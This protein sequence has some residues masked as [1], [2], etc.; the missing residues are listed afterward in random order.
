MNKRYIVF[1]FI[2]G[3]IALV[4]SCG[5]EGFDFKDGYQQGDETES[6]IMTDTTMGKADKS[7]YHRARIYPGLVGENVRRIQ[8]TT[9]S[10]LIDREYI[11]DFQYKVSYTPS[12]IYSTGLYAPAGENVRI[13]VPA[14]VVGL[15]AQIGVHTDNITGKDA[16]RRDAI[17]YTRKELFPGNNYV[18]NLYGGTL[19]I[20]SQKTRPTPVNLK[21]S[22]ATKA[23]DFVL[24][25]MTVSDWQ[26][27]V[28]ANDVPWMD[29]IGK[30][31]AFSVPRSLVVKLIQS[32]KMDHVDEALQL[33]DDSYEKDYY[34]W[35]GLSPT[36]VNPI[37]R[38]PSLWERG[39]MDIHPS[40]GYAHSGSP[41]I[42]QEDEYWLD[43]LTNPN[44]IKKGTSWGT[45]HEVGHNYQAGSSW[46]WS[47]LGETTNNLFIF[48]AARNRGETNRI[49]FHP[50]L[51]TSIPGALKF[52]AYNEVK[53]FKPFPTGYGLDADDPFARLTPF[54]Q[55]F[56]KVKG[57]NGESGWDFFPYIY[58]KARNENFFTS[59]DQAKKDYFFRQLCHFTGKDFHRFFFA[60]GIP[61]STAAKREMRNLYPPMANKVWDYNPLTFTGGDDVLATKYSLPRA[62]FVYTSNVSTATGESTGKIDAMQDG[63][64]DTYWHTCYSGCSVAT[65]LP[66]E[67]MIDMK[68]INAFKGFFIQNRQNNTYATKVIVRISQ[69]NKN[70]VDMGTYDLAK[71]SET[72]AQRNVM[73][74][75]TF[76]KIVE[77]QYMKFSFPEKN[78][79]GENHVAL[80]ELGVFY[81]I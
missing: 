2:A 26:K 43:E 38:Y 11:S 17:I 1:G 28:L 72:T 46:S 34:N 5:K 73:R 18:G 41:W 19:W 77:A 14:G 62:A 58:S 78:L 32:G 22:G 65:N 20:I 4:S 70:W 33:W 60:W 61:I 47:D 56:D 45:Y 27:Q 57:K 74:E 15:T 76:D 69:D 12:P 9:L 13:T 80:A 29:L 35:M 59:L 30:R 50:A 66:V 37:N 75:F 81:D 71:S 54:L 39:V 51:K 7:L 31:T 16:P 36:A 24:G 55:I 6:P 68:T 63:K 10:L 53:T 48:N 44:T 21:I 3:M 23:N 8:D 49:D 79:S 64:S 40:A 42:M 52:A 67:I 25:K